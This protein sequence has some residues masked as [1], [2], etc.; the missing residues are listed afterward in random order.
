MWNVRHESRSLVVYMIVGTWCL[1]MSTV[2]CS[3]KCIDSICPSVLVKHS[4]RLCGLVFSCSV[5]RLRCSVRGHGLLQ[6]AR[7]GCNHYVAPTCS[8][9][10]HIDCLAR[11]QPTRFSPNMTVELVTLC[12]RCWICVDAQVFLSCSDA[13]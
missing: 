10:F 13:G 7:I 12:P 9:L 2:T 5:Q 4:C 3:R 8:I 6:A 11:A 1:S